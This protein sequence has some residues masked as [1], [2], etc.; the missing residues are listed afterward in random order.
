[1]NN[2]HRSKHDSWLISIAAITLYEVFVGGSA[3]CSASDS[4]NLQQELPAAEALYREGLDHYKKWELAIAVEKF[5]QVIAKGKKTANVYSYLGEALIVLE[6]YDEALTNLSEAIRLDPRDVHAFTFRGLT[7][8]QLGNREEAI[9]DFSAGLAITPNELMA[10][11]LE[12]RGETYWAIGWLEKAAE[13]FEAIIAHDPKGA[14]GYFLRGK[15][16]GAKGKFREAIDDWSSALDR[17][18]T[19]KIPLFYR[20]YGYICLKE[21]DKALRDYTAL[22]QAVPEA[23]IVH[24]YRGWIHGRLENHRLA[25]T[26]LTYAREHG[27]RQPFVYLFLA[28]SLAAQGQIDQALG[29]RSPE[30]FERH[31]GSA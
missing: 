26:D 3:V 28:H 20:G 13:D 4:K 6:R 31:E 9:Q 15:L 25:E 17:D 14:R 22:L 1:M 23:A 11:L 8:A 12:A 18:A 21:Y 7:H 10:T 27:Y 24:A 5:S 16:L 2:R 29:Y 19:R 30:E